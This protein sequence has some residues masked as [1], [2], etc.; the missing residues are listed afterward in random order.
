MIRFFRQLRQRLLSDN[1]F[2]K[3]L[4]YA[5][6]EILLVVVGILIAFQVDNWNEAK[7]L[8]KVERSLLS[9]LKTNLESNVQN[10]ESDIEV[11]VQG[12]SAIHFLLDHLDARRPYRDTLDVLF[13]AADYV[14]ETVL[15]SSAFETLKSSGL[16]LV[17]NDRLR[18]RIIDLFE[19]K[20]PYL[21]QETRR[22]EDQLWTATS[23]PLYQRYFRREVSGRAHPTDYESLL[24]DEEFTNM[25]SFRLNMREASTSHKRNARDQTLEVIHIISDE[26]K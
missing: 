12:A 5:V 17:S 24:E 14:P 21:M 4:L 3:Y 13:Q 15:S 25:L 23:V 20:Y 18:K 7:K 6:G 8:A 26:L 10:L 2:G 1:Q 11:Q 19:V 22:L 16:G 9:E